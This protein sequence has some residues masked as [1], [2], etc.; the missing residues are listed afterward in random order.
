MT[1]NP[2]AIAASQAMNLIQNGSFESLLGTSV[3]WSPD[4]FG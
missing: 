3:E 2:L 1:V 4:I